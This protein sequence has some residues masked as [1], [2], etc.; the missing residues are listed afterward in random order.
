MRIL[1]YPHQMDVGG[2]QIN[3]VQLAGALRERGHHVIVA[4]QPGPLVQRVHSMKLEHIDIPAP[5]RRPSLRVACKL[6]RLV[7]QHGIDVVHAFESVP[8]IEALFGP[9]LRHRT[10]VV[11]TV[12]SMSVRSYMP[13]NIPLTVGTAQILSAA[14]HAGHHRVTMLEPPVDTE[15]DHPALDGHIFRAEYGIAEGEVLV[16]VVCRLAR[17]LK[18]EGLQTACEAAGELAQEGKPLRLVIV[19]DGPARSEVAEAADRANRAASRQV[20]LMTG[21]LADPRW[22]YAAADIV[23]GQGGSALRGMAFAKPLIV[24]GEAGFVEIVTPSSAPTFLK[25][26][27]YGLGH[28]SFG[29]GAVALR[30]A[31]DRL[32]GSPDLRRDLGEFGRHLVVDRFSL[33]GAAPLLEQEYLA[34]IR[35]SGH[36]GPLTVDLIRAA[37]GV[38]VNKVRRQYLHWRGTVEMDDPNVSP[39]IAYRLAHVAAPSPDVR[40]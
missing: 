9:G 21:E 29:G 30:T 12:M 10:P 32:I 16:V 38:F 2:C 13:R 24:L 11:G 37:S 15:A 14:V 17:G 5:K 26:G 4:S 3:A 39:A 40:P 18:L 31:L 19:G 20:V 22:A 36:V 23:L 1:V 35:A 34:A 28:G 8:A 6:A 27:W 33:A 25:Q 7:S